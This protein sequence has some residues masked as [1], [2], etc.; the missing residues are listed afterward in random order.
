[1]SFRVPERAGGTRPG[2]PSVTFV[3]PTRLTPAN[4]R[5]GP[6]RRSQS[7]HGTHG[8]HGT[9]TRDHASTLTVARRAAGD[10]PCPQTA[11][12]VDAFLALQRSVGN[13]AVQRQVAAQGA[14]PQV[15]GNQEFQQKLRE[16]RQLLESGQV[17][18][19][20]RRDAEAAIARVNAALR[21]IQRGES[22]GSTAGSMASGG[23]LVVG[24]L[25]ADDAT[26]IG[27]ADDVLIPFAL[28]FVGAAALTAW[29]QSTTAE[30]KARVAEAARRALVEAVEVIG[31]IV[32]AAKVGDQIR[33][34]T[35]QLAIHL[36]R[37]LGTA[38]AG[39]PPDHQNDPERDRPH[40]WREIKNFVKEIRDKGLSP[41]QLWRELSKKFTPEQ[42]REILNALKEAAK[43][44]GEDPPDFPPIAFP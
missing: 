3:A 21:D 43:K 7:A 31:S 27:V 15:A 9:H 39:M 38:V 30:D 13:A 36:A 12:R 24:G 32:L 22:A 37:L 20:D 19:E 2:G 41:K 44:M 40:W 5:A 6:A 28:L 11:Q 33:S 8:T 26:G 10:C 23:L 4:G 42:M 29:A 34:H 16:Y 18:A 35:N 14:P 25:A 1:V 17:G